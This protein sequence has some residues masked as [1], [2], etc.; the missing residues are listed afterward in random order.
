MAAGGAGTVTKQ[1]ESDFRIHRFYASDQ[2][3]NVGGPRQNMGMESPI[4]LLSD[5]RTQVAEALRGVSDAHLLHHASDADLAAAI[6]IAGDIARL[7]E[8]V[9]IDGVAEL[10]ERSWQP[11]DG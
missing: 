11:G 7:V 2:G 5:L 10:A 9:L 3:W 8:G 4:E 1:S 6:A